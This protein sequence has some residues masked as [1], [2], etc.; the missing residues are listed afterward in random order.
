MAG[1]VRVQR[2][3]LR[4]SWG[5]VVVG[6]IARPSELAG[7]AELVGRSLR[8]LRGAVQLQSWTYRVVAVDVVSAATASITIFLARFGIPD[9]AEAR[10]SVLLLAI[11]LVPA[12]VTILT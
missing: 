3:H 10:S 4:S 1:R 5:Q 7:H 6:E 9:S 11:S 8:T 2:D 12:W